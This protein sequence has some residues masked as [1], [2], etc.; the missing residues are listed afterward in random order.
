VA[1]VANA[2][3]PLLDPVERRFHLAQ[4]A[5]RTFERRRR[6]ILRII[7]DGDAALVFGLALRRNVAEQN[8]DSRFE[9]ALAGEKRLLKVVV[10]T[11]CWCF[12]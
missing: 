10:R 1:D 12:R 4:R 6:P 3:V 5:A 7:I 8:G 9:F 11:A 2:V